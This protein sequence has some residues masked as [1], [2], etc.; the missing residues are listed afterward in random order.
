MII[1]AENNLDDWQ[2]LPQC[3]NLNDEPGCLKIGLVPTT[4][5]KIGRKRLTVSYC[6]AKNSILSH[7]VVSFT[8]L[9]VQC[10]R[11]NHY[12]CTISELKLAIV[13]VS[14]F[15][16]SSLADPQNVDENRVN[17]K[18]KEDVADLL[19]QIVLPI[20]LGLIIVVVVL[21]IIICWRR[22]ASQASSPTS[23]NG[24]L[25]NSTGE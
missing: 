21:I 12:C 1:F 13:G 10:I 14:F 4:Q 20:V 9:C 6:L 5:P 17:L 7:V 19:I 2:I 15:T 3:V 22:K 8:V 23:S 25:T 24:G 18:T 16:D 11:G